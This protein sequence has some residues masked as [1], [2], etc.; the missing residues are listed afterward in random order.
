MPIETAC[1][2]CVCVRT[3]V[4]VLTWLH[5]L[6]SVSWQ[7]AAAELGHGPNGD[8]SR[9]W[10]FDCNTHTH[11]PQ[12][13]ISLSPRRALMPTHT[14]TQSRS[15]VMTSSLP[16]LA[17]LHVHQQP[18]HSLNVSLSRS[19]S[20]SHL[21]TYT[22]THTTS[23]RSNVL[24][25]LRAPVCSDNLGGIPESRFS[26]ASGFSIPEREVTKTFGQCPW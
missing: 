1:T 25:S 19:V 17:T 18:P 13:L 10:E 4:C 14:H 5:L 23:D 12:L 6:V 7:G 26:E 21:H 20:L 15:P 3:L 9:L 22:H 16:T 8:V 11:L 2:L 24:M